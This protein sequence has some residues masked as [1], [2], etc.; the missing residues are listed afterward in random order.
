M[1]N[2]NAISRQVMLLFICFTFHSFQTL[3]FKYYLNCKRDYH[4][5][6]IHSF[7][8]LQISILFGRTTKMEAAQD[9]T[10]HTFTNSV[11][12]NQ[13]PNYCQIYSFVWARIENEITKLSANRR[14]L[15][16]WGHGSQWTSTGYIHCSTVNPLHP[17]ILKF[18][19]IPIWYNR[20]A[21]YS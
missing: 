2:S 17:L 5:K 7:L 16:E 21:C 15:L 19:S 6:Y 10:L 20:A 8:T 12:A 13:L 3:C 4:L 11:D 14:A 9:W 18:R 1:I